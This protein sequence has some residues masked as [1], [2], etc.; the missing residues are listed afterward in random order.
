MYAFTSGFLKLVDLGVGLALSAAGALGVCVQP[1]RRHQD[2]KFT[3]IASATA[4]LTDP[5]PTHERD[6][7]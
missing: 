6:S 5:L 2:D 4:S 3:P 1:E 7:S